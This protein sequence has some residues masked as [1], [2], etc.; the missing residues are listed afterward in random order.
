[1]RAEL[2]KDV[3]QVRRTQLGGS[4]GAGRIVGEPDLFSG[5]SGIC[6]DG[7]HRGLH[8]RRTGAPGP[9]PTGRHATGASLVSGIP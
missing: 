2:R 3:V 5:R 6:L 4:A 9:F 8:V 1:M 7:T